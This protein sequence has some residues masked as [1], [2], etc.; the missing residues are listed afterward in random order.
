MHKFWQ[1]KV[2]FYFRKTCF[3]F[4]KL[5][6]PLHRG[7]FCQF[8]LRWIYY[9]GTNKSTGKETDKTHLCA[10]VWLAILN[11]VRHSCELYASHLSIKNCHFH[12]TGT[13]SWFLSQ[14]K[15]LINFLQCM[16]NACNQ[17]WREIWK[18]KEVKETI[19]TLF[20]T[21]IL[22][23]WLFEYTICLT[24]FQSCRY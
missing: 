7:A 20:L 12:L 21:R 13:I 9:Y 4:R 6:L 18:K 8:L 1:G 17:L 19:L 23:S 10:L 11:L 22:Q 15:A 16:D 3:H 5:C 14:N 2:C 24:Y